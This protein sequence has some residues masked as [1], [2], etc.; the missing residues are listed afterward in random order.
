M[1]K[2]VK[3][4][5]ASLCAAAAVVVVCIFGVRNSMHYAAFQAGMEPFG[6]QIC[7]RSGNKLP[8]ES[9]VSDGEL[10]EMAVLR[11]TQR[12]TDKT[13]LLCLLRRIDDL[14]PWKTAACAI[15]NE[16]GYA[17]LC[18]EEPN[19]FLYDFSYGGKE[20]LSLGIEGIR[21][22]WKIKRH[23]VFYGKDAVSTVYFEEDQLDAST[24][25][26]IQ[27]DGERYWIYL[28]SYQNSDTTPEVDIHELLMKNGCIAADSEESGARE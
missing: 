1:K 3:K 13:M 18:M 7:L 5:I 2:S 4:V 15:E 27:Q 24:A 16:S 25:V 19:P 8:R 12:G 22:S 6:Y 14:D 28:L 11:G 23:Q 21:S 9:Y 10:Y 26:S 17:Q 20:R